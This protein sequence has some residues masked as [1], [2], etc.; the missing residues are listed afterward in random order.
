MLHYKTQLYILREHCSESRET[1][2]RKA[3]LSGRKECISGGNVALE[4]T[5]VQSGPWRA[6]CGILGGQGEE[7]ILSLQTPRAALLHAAG[8]CGLTLSSP[9][10][11][12]STVMTG[13]SFRDTCLEKSFIAEYT[14]AGYILVTSRMTYGLD[15]DS[16]KSSAGGTGSIRR[17]MTWRYRKKSVQ[18]FFRV[19]Y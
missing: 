15:V 4:P 3:K 14:Y 18:V 8:T 11:E 12:A 2:S 13:S 10:Q 6:E 9:V 1:A 19:S 17:D 7:G 5:R 16:C